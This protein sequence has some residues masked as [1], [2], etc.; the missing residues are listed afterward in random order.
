MRALSL[1]FRDLKILHGIYARQPQLPLVPISDGAGDVIECGAEVARLQTG[2]RVAPIYMQGWHKGPMT[3]ER[4]GWMSRGGDIDGTATEYLLCHEDDVVTIPDTLSYE[5]AACVICAGVTAWHALVFEG[6]VKAGDT[7][8]V[9]GSGGVSIFGLQIA[10][11][12]GGRVIATS[13][14]DAKLERLLALGAWKGINTTKVTAWDDEVRRLTQGR[15]VDQ[16]L[17]VGG[18]DTTPKSMN[19]TRDEGQVHLIGN[20]TGQFGTRDQA[21]RG[22]RTSRLTAGSR[23]M[24]EDLLRAIDIHGEMPVIDRRFAFDDLKE[25]LAYLETGNHVG[26][27]VITF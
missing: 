2:Q 1:N 17:E 6:H 12:S 7:I 11:M 15:G 4:K 24:T 19:A 13:R 16:V 25:A 22:I 23:E 20:L 5:E 9:M 8:L 26:N 27:V 18:Q 3:R 21:V 10:K 14:H